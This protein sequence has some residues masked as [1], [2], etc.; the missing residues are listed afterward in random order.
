MLKSK[1]EE[2][3]AKTREILTEVVGD[4]E[5]LEPPVNLAKILKHF[6]L[7]LEQAKFQQ[8]AVGGAFDREKKIIYLAVDENPIRQAFTVAHELG[9]L[10]L[11][12][13]RQDIFFRHQVKDF[14]GDSKEDEKEAN[15]FAASL[16]MPKEVVTKAWEKY[17]S[18][19]L[20][21]Q[22]FGVSKQAA[23]WR[24]KNLELLR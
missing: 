19:E 8:Y 3:E 2:I 16:L 7:S 13:K 21:A 9:H 24:L 12:K 14:N 6:E 15:W 23:Y 4:L 20:I 22:Y 5:N 1:I 11:H 17:K 18:I 10:I